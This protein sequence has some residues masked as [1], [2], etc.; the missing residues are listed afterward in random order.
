MRQA[1][2]KETTFQYMEEKLATEVYQSDF[3][4]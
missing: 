3:D 2:A 4:N 1:V